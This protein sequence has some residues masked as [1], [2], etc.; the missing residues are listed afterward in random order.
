MRPHTAGMTPGTATSTRNG[1]SLTGARNSASTTHYASPNQPHSNHRQTGW[2]QP[3]HTRHSEIG[4]ANS[5]H[6]TEK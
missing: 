5:S 3:S 2:A 4:G 6:S 1:H